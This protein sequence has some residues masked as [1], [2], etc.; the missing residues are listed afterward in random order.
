MKKISPQQL[1]LMK[2]MGSIGMGHAATGLA[3]LLGNRVSIRSPEVKCL[4]LAE[5]TQFLGSAE[6]LVSGICFQVTGDVAGS[7]L[8]VLP[9]D[10]KSKLLHAW[11][12]REGEPDSSYTESALREFGNIAIGGCLMALSQLTG[13]MMLCSIPSLATDMLGALLDELLIE[14]AKQTDEVVLIDAEF[15]IEEK[16][17]TGFFLLIFDP[18]SME[19]IFT[20]L[21]IK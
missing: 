7:I 19:K 10:T 8:L 11:L 18:H 5:V 2:E 9:G 17:I 21:K 13:L 12:G 6:Q 1:D 16:K 20:N 14:T 15:V 4:P 3:N